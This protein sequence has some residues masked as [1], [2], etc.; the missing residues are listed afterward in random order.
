MN[1]RKRLEKLEGGRMAPGEEW[2]TLPE[3]LVYC[4]AVERY[5]AR[6]NGEEPPPYSPEEIA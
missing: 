1:A 3:V 6:K 5:R 4:K 2:V